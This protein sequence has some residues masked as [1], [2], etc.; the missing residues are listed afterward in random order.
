MSPL[1]SGMVTLRNLVRSHEAVKVENAIFL[2]DAKFSPYLGHYP[3][4]GE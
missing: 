3:T 1:F 4:N 2:R